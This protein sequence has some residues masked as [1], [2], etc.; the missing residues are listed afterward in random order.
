[1]GWFDKL[2]KEDQKL[3]IVDVSARLHYGLKGVAGDGSVRK[4]TVIYD[5]GTIIATDGGHNTSACG[6]KPIL[7]KQNRI[8]ELIDP[9]PFTMLTGYE[10]YDW[11]NANH[12]DYRGLI[13][14]GLAIEDTT[15]VYDK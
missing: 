14:K 11:Y 8:A 15:G 12:I 2:S 6:F 4:M 7:R 3:F 13:E 10:L 1:M 9:K 5:S